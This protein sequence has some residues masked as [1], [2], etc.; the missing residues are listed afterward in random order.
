MIIV[1]LALIVSTI[2]LGARLASAEV[3]W[4]LVW[5]DEFEG[6]KLDYTKWGVEQNAHGGGN[7]ELQFFVERP[8]NVRVEN[9]HLVIQARKE[10]FSAAGQ[11]RDFT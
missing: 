2:A 5:S 3:P 1:K 4:K 11:T 10:K 8:E 7:G 6:A 9:G